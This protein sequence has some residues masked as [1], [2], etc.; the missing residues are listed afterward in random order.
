MFTAKLNLLFITS[1]TEEEEKKTEENYDSS[2]TCLLAE[3]YTH[4]K[5][6]ITTYLS[7]G[8][9]IFSFCSYE[10]QSINEILEWI[11]RWQNQ[12]LNEQA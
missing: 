2:I 10:Q 3:A 6:L 8:L 4:C 11:W 5:G 1:P 12:W 9:I 7:M